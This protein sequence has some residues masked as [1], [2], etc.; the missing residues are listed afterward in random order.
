M[1]ATPYGSTPL[2]KFAFAVSVEARRFS[3]ER[4]AIYGYVTTTD[5]RREFPDYC[6]RTALDVLYVLK[7]YGVLEESWPKLFD[8]QGRQNI[9]RYVLTSQARQGLEEL[10]QLLDELKIEMGSFN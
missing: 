1:R 2:C 4:A 10:S 5:I 7:K 8:Q 3:I 9:T 6:Q